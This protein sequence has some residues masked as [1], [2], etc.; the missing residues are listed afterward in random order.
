[1]EAVEHAKQIRDSHI[2]IPIIGVTSF[3]P[4]I[5]RHDCAPADINGYL[6]KPLNAGDVKQSLR[7]AFITAHH[8]H[9]A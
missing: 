1:M 9:A 8:L 3:S 5:I 4:S 6:T 7:E 2:N